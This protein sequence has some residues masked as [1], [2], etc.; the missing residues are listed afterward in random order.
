MVLP[1]IILPAITS[2]AQLTERSVSLSSSSISAQNV[3]YEVKFTS[4]GAAGA[5]VVDFCSNS[6]LIGQEC[7]PPTDF[8]ASEAGSTTPNFTD[9][10]ALSASTLRVTGPIAAGAQMTVVLNGIDNPSTAGPMYARII[11][12]D[13]ALNANNYQSQAIGAG[14]VDDGSAAISITN[15]IG[16]SADVL[17]SMTFCISGD[18]ISE[19]CSEVSSPMLELGQTVG[20]ITALVPDEL[21]EGTVYT[22]ISTNAARGA[23]VSLRSS[24]TG[25]GGLMRAG[26]PGA[27]DILPALT[28]GV[29]AG[30]SRFGI[31]TSTATDTGDNALGTLQP[32]SGS[33]Y[34]NDS[35]ALNYVTGDASGVTGPFGDPFLDTAGEPASNKNMALIFGVSI[36]NNTPAGSYSADISLVATGRF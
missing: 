10:S 14:H 22:Q 25:C 17:E 24:A 6:P 19:D 1:A 18:T 33:I 29:V 32:V 16:V 27:C 7:T 35:F 2:A 4:A 23:V 26:A 11:T 34:N 21:S 12:Y 5:F 36:N 3:S 15:T 28:E 9:V 20:D 30:E 13:T 8:D 31:K